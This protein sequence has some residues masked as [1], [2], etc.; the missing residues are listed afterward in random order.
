MSGCAKAIN[1]PEFLIILQMTIWLQFL[2]T[3]RP[4]YS[5]RYRSVIDDDEVLA[6]PCKVR[7]NIHHYGVIRN[8]TCHG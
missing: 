1:S 4:L 3:R 7:G 5:L 2:Y 6:L 8:T